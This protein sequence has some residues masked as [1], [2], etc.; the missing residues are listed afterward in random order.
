MQEV[1][2]G[3]HL[4]LN[5]LLT[6]L[7]GESYLLLPCS[8]GMYSVTLT[9]KLDYPDGS[10]TTR[11]VNLSSGRYNWQPK[12]LSMREQ[13]TVGGATASMSGAAI[14]V[15]TPGHQYQFLAVRLP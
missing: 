3:S 14:T 15:V 5:Q 4:A 11:Q 8:A 2:N 9:E 10:S 12:T 1:P 7:D 13:G 6:L